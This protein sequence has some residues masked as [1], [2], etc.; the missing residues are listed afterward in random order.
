M[1]TGVKAR[2]IIIAIAIINIIILNHPD[3]YHGHILMSYFIFVII[4]IISD[5]SSQSH[6]RCLLL[7]RVT[8]IITNAKKLT[9]T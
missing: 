7:R 5:Q 6:M 1:M 3:H 9:N 8:L 4:M 2:N